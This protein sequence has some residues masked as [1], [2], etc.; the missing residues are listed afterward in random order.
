MTPPTPPAHIVVPA[1]ADT[2]ADTPAPVPMP[3]RADLPTA[4]QV[5][6][7][8]AKPRSGL[9]ETG[10]SGLSD[11]EVSPMGSP[12]ALL[13]GDIRVAILARCSTE[14]QQDPRQSIIRQVNNSR[15]ALPTAWIVSAHYWDV[16]SG[17]LSL[18]QRGRGVDLE[19]FDIP[20]SREGGIAD[21]LAEAEHPGRR[22]DVVIC[23]SVSRVARRA[24]EGISIERAL[25][26]AGIPLFAANEPISLSGSRA[27][28]I[29]QRRI[30]QSV[31]EWEVLNTLE[32][33]WGGLCTH[34]REGWNIGKPPYG[35]RARTCRHPNPTKGTPD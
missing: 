31:A 22:F 21:L 26:H 15:A 16:E 25:E 5:A 28:R 29:L 19:R 8:A 2:T 13:R 23:E 4:V 34:V 6:V 30:N 7:P 14:D 17:R 33:S 9:P 24:F 32:Q 18:E 20:V 3:P 12:L 1:A 11:H 10:P 27:Q 35:Y